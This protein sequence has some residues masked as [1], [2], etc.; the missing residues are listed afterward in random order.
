MI[1]LLHS[2]R[3]HC[4]PS[5]SVWLWQL[6][7]LFLL[8]AA[9]GLLL[10]PMMLS[11]C[12]S[13]VTEIRDGKAWQVETVDFAGL[14]LSR[15]EEPVKTSWQLSV[16]QVGKLVPRGGWLVTVG[17]VLAVAGLLAGLYVTAKPLQHVFSLVLL[18][19]VVLIGAG[20]F[21]M[22]IGMLGAYGVLVA[23]AAAAVAAI[24]YFKDHRYI[25][26]T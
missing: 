22:G 19:G 20:L 17:A 5:A 3:G 15:T 7:R 4:V 23:V 18:A 6:G 11:G 16:A 24:Y 2:H 1:N 25:K 8:L 13:T 9:L 26:A 10:L 12:T 14:E 21:L